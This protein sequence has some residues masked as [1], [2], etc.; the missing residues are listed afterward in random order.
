MTR[1]ATGGNRAWY[2]IMNSA[3][4]ADVHI[5]DEVG[6][7]GVSAQDFIR[8]LSGVKGAVSLHLNTPG[9][10]VFDGIA[11][12][13]ALKARP[14]VSV[15]IEGLA[16]SI[17]SVIAQAASPGKL[18]I[19]K[20]AS[21]MIH[22]GFSQA[23]GNAQEMRDLADLLDKQSDQIAG[24]YAD[25]TG[26]PAAF[27]RGEMKQEK[28]YTGDEAVAAGLADHVLDVP[29]MKGSWDPSKVA[30]MPESVIA[31]LA[32]PR[33]AA[34]ENPGKSGDD[35][36][37]VLDPDGTCRFD[38]DG[39]GDDDATPEGDTDHDYFDEDGKQVKAI[40]PVP[41]AMKKAARKMKK[42]VAKAAKIIRDAV[43]QPQ[44]YHRDP[45]ENV[46]C[47][48][49]DKYNSMDAIYCDQCGMKLAGRS[50][51]KVAASSKAAVR[52][53]I[54]NI[55]TSPW[56]ASKAWSAGADS[57]DPAAFYKAI[58]AGRRAGDP[59]LQSSWALPYKYSPGSAPNAAAVRN[60]LARIGQTKGLTNKP[61]AQALLER[62]MK[63]VNPDYTSSSDYVDPSLL[64][65][66]LSLA[67]GR[68]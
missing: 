1:P 27:W 61:E 6:C 3:A 26:K 55:D 47:P 50:D 32:G 16:A 11:I 22:D 52:L 7:F 29:A 51:V 15:M 19:A 5:Y 37:W 34:S 39:D 48:G 57:D 62:L 21:M 14:D 45:D 63:Q 9:G 41:P 65:A 68:E 67:L 54:L 49:C 20:R 2:T 8:D 56:D 46:C 13:N 59:K 23:V 30:S 28:W 10:E 17:G 31:A 43:Y 12:Y 4:G 18:G 33:N 66:A 24:V 38:P 42:A 60:A 35:S 40:P 53:A 36:G 58:C 64:S 44:P 25:R